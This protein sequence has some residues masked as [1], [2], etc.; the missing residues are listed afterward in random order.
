M[1]HH[2]DAPTTQLGS[3]SKSASGIPSISGS[4]DRDR[5]HHA[6]TPP[7]QIPDPAGPTDA[8]LVLLALRDPL[9]FA[10]L[11]QRYVTSVYRYCYRQTSD[12]DI[13]TDLT[14]Q[15][16][17]RALEA[18]PK[19][20]LRESDPPC[21]GTGSGGTFRSWLFTIAHNAVIDARRRH[22]PSVPL[23]DRHHHVAD[24]ERGPEDQAVLRDELDRLIVVLDRIPDG[25]R[26]I[27]EL[28]L[29]GLT[30]AEIATA[31]SLSRPAVKSAQTRAYA[32]LRELLGPPPASAS[33]PP[34]T[35]PGVDP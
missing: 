34:A 35:H 25:Q 7:D 11:Y 6:N 30:T 17:T 15:I 13:A 1:A 10:P 9:A 31:L 16:F 33:S 14:A 2:R 28:R 19:F 32:R 12:P 22:R 4:P 29:A 20:R 8:A 23:E 26:Q 5:N 18:L 24:D 27:I 21:N 3:A